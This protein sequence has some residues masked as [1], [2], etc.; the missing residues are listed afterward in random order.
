MVAAG[1]KT[2]IRALLKG[3]RARRMRMPMNR[4]PGSASVMYHWTR[5]PPGT[6]HDPHRVR[7]RFSCEVSHPMDDGPGV[8][9][10]E[11]AES[12]FSQSVAGTSRAAALHGKEQLAAGA[13]LLAG[14]QG[15]SA[16]DGK[17]EKRSRAS[18]LAGGRSCQFNSKCGNAVTAPIGSG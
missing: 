10:A 7:L 8:E 2:T 16:V 14:R 6:S 17:A 11:R 15:V 3:S 18:W 5:M 13:H 9:I 1:E 4:S 12:Q